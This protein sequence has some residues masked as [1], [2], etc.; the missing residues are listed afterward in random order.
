MQDFVLQYRRKRTQPASSR[1]NL[2]RLIVTDTSERATELQVDGFFSCCCM[3]VFCRMS[4]VARGL[5]F[6]FFI[7]WM[8]ALLEYVTVVGCKYVGVTTHF[9]GATFQIRCQGL[10]VESVKGVTVQSARF[11]RVPRSE[12]PFAWGSHYLG[13]TGMVIHL[14]ARIRNHH[15]NDSCYGNHDHRPHK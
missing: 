15:C 11:P 6:L 14:V 9:P 12:D 1:P 2:L 5:Q 8:G 10:S 3:F 4:P 13:F 7:C